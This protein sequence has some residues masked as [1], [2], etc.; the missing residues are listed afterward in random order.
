MHKFCNDW[1]VHSWLTP[2]MSSGKKRKTLGD[3]FKLR[4]QKNFLAL[5]EEEVRSKSLALRLCFPPLSLI[6]C[7]FS[8][9]SF[10]FLSSPAARY[11]NWVGMRDPTA[12]AEPSKL[13]QHHF[14]GMCGFR[15]SLHLQFLWGAL[16]CPLPGN[17][18]WNQVHHWHCRGCTWSLL[19]WL[20]VVSVVM[21][22]TCELLHS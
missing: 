16:L 8:S 20:N 22:R 21:G 18:T 13:P 14:C 11:R 4:F 9:Q 17:A 10:C 12:C 7:S 15:V 1:S 19:F 2:L 5:L 3:H 6:I